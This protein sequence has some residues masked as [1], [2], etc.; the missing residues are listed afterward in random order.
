MK[1]LF[2]DFDGTLANNWKILRGN[3]TSLWTY[4]AYD[5][6]T[7]LKYEIDIDEYRRHM[8]NGGYSWST[9]EI[10]YTENTGQ[11]WWDKFFA[12]LNIYYKDNSISSD[13][14]EKASIYIKNQITD[15]RNYTLFDDAVSVLQK[16]M[17]LGYKNYILSNNFPELVNI[18]K[19]LG[20]AEYFADYIVS[21]NIGYEKPRIE[22]FQYAMNIAGSPEICYMIGDNPIAD[23]QGGKSAGMKTILVNSKRESEADYICG[24]LSENP[25]ILV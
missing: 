22:I 6:L 19:D 20:C 23:I 18:I 4:S 14:A 12:H 17:E 13:D 11:K 5:V 15:Y 1:A 7:E 3:P 10:S 8:N 16:C 9:P 21:A 2:W 25:S 24:S